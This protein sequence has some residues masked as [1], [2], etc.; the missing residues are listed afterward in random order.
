[1][2]DTYGFSKVKREVFL[3]G[4]SRFVLDSS[5]ICIE[6]DNPKYK[7]I[8][9][10]LDREDFLYRLVRPAKGFSNSDPIL[11]EF[12][13]TKFDESEEQCFV[14][15]R[16]SVGKAISVLEDLDRKVFSMPFKKPK[17]DEEMAAG[18]VDKSTFES[19]GTGKEYVEDVSRKMYKGNER[20]FVGTCKENV[21]IL[22]EV[23]KVYGHRYY[24][25]NFPWDSHEY[26]LG[27]N[28]I[29]TA[30]KKVIAEMDS[31]DEGYVFLFTWI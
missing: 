22:K 18:I 14:V 9:G 19:Y 28:N 15:T 5:G 30:L 3:N 6:E 23:E 16:E 31:T 21:D 7:E 25:Y 11:S 10:D 2:G 8:V 29:I 20:C 1:M 17:D 4:E 26:D 24:H 27:A 12:L 13:K